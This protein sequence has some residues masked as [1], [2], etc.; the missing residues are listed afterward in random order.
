MVLEDDNSLARSRAIAAGADDYM[1]GP[2]T[3]E[4]LKS[5]LQLYAQ[6]EGRQTSPDVVGTLTLDSEAHQARCQGRLIPLRPS[7]L[8][9]LE[10]FLAQPNRLLSRS[11]I[12]ALLGKEDEI[13]DD[14]TVDVWVGRLRRTLEAHGV[15]GVLRTVRSLGYVLDMPRG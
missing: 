3:A 2:L 8:Q 14:R 6:R 7:E 4:S 15:S 11:K 5:R 9:L 10:V 12:I 1:A 13:G